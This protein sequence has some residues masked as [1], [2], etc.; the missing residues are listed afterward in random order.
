MSQTP[1]P[2]QYTLH[3]HERSFVNDA[4]FILEA[5]TPFMSFHVGDFI[6]PRSLGV[7]DRELP[8]DYW[9][10]ITAVVHRIWEIENKHIGHLIGVTVIAAPKNQ[11]DQ[12]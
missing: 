7:D 9:W 11:R 6:N 10:Q 2:V 12:V 5:T 8:E 1:L 3:I 4:R